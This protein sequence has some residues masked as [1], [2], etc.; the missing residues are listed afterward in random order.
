V[1]SATARKAKVARG[2]DGPERK[3]RAHVLE[4]SVPA[5][6]NVVH[7]I[8]EMGKPEEEASSDRSVNEMPV[9]AGKRVSRS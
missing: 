9:R 2:K 7:V 6:L 4:P 8:E 3:K 1:V 5:H